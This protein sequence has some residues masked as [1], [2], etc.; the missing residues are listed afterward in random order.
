MTNRTE[1][2]RT[3]AVVGSG[4][5]AEALARALGRS[6][7]ELV[8]VCARNPVRGPKVARIGGC[9][10]CADPARAAA[11]DLYLVT[12]SD[13]AVAEAA[14]ALRVPEGAVVAHTAGCVPLEALPG[15]QRA[16]VYPFQT[17][18]A[19]REVD[20]AEVP[21]LVEA[22]APDVAA[23]I[24]A[25][26]RGLSRTVL[27]AD[28]A[29]R[30][31]VH[32][33]GVFACNFANHLFALGGRMLRQAG[34]PEGLLGPIVAETAAKAAAAD[35]PAAVQTGP[36]VRGDRATQ[37]RHLALLAGDPLLET[38]YRTITQSIWETSKK[39]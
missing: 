25:F 39:I 8:E 23:R 34:L 4:N 22:S 5:V 16:V 6:P 3:V 11:A 20:F 31:R 7:F 24:T 35:D 1:P 19:G 33:A 13:R 27:P 10:W 29:T 9:A 17:F 26:A 2:I 15:A 12:V 18:T 36:A 28:A 32:L 21:L 37:E 30:A 14:G 38:I